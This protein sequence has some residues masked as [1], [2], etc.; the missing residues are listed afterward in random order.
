MKIKSLCA[1]ERER[2]ATKMKLRGTFMASN[3]FLKAKKKK[4]KKTLKFK[5]KK[6]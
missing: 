5:I 6:L 3:A 2:E 4:K 1:K